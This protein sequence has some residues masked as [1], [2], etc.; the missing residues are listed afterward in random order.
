MVIHRFKF[1]CSHRKPGR[2]QFALIAKRVHPA[3]TAFRH[4]TSSL[5]SVETRVALKHADDFIAG[6]SSQ[7]FVRVSINILADKLNMPVS[8]QEMASPSVETAEDTIL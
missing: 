5:S 2:E 3:S 1:T 8:E 4:A 6:S 7:R